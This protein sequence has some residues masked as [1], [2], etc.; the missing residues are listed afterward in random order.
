MLATNSAHSISIRANQFSYATPGLTVTSTNA[1]ICN[2][3]FANNSDQSLKGSVT[4]LDTMQCISVVK[5]LQPKTYKRLDLNDDA[6]RVGLLAQNVASAIPAEWSNLVGSTEQ[7]DAYADNQGNEVPAK[8]SPLT[9]DYARLV[10]PM[11][12]VVK[13]LISRVEA[14]EAAAAS[15]SKMGTWHSA[16]NVNCCASK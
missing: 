11:P 16:V 5:A 2:T 3:T 4:A 10:V 13:D 7:S 6:V 15:Y 8:S 9:L 12:A 1:V 14:L